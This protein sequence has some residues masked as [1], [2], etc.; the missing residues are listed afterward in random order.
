MNVGNESS[1]EEGLPR[2]PIR[3]G[4]SH[5]RGASGRSRIQRLGMRRRQTDA[6]QGP[7]RSRI[8]SPLPEVR[9]AVGLHRD[10]ERAWER[11]P[12]EIVVGIGN[13]ACRLVRRKTSRAANSLRSDAM[14]LYPTQLGGNI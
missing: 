4:H 5:P 12:R 9:R 1:N 3:V 8:G 14:R 2:A 6:S 7:T 11:E 10:A 13:A